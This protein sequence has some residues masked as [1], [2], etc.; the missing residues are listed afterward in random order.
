MFITRSSGIIST[1]HLQ[2]EMLEH[3]MQLEMPLMHEMFLVTL[4]KIFMHQVNS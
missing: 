1:K 3:S 4:T 2:L